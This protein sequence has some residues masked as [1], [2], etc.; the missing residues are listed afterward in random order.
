MNYIKI[1]SK[2][3]KIKINDIIKNKVQNTLKEK[4]NNYKS[5]IIKSKNND[6]SSK[7]NLF[8]YLFDKNNNKTMTLFPVGI[9]TKRTKLIHKIE[10]VHT[11][12]IK[13]NLI[14]FGKFNEK[15][16]NKTL[17][18]EKK[19]TNVPQL[20]NFNRYF[21]IK[22][23]RIM[24]TNKPYNNVTFYNDNKINKIKA[25]IK[26]SEI[27]KSIKI[28]ILVNKNNNFIKKRNTNNKQKDK[29]SKMKNISIIN[30]Y[31]TIEKYPIL[32]KNNTINNLIYNQKK[33]IKVN[34]SKNRNINKYHS[35]KIKLINIFNLDKSINKNISKLNNNKSNKTSI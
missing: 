11:N 3:K 21:K 31:H 25:T 14:N 33:D 2:I 1:N 35:R 15:N 20:I 8:E 22:N 19:P 12:P 18:Q 4:N 23:G 28:C 29:K 16:N 32:T 17:S 34:K 13:R 9:Q 27:I 10:S 30:N 5:K 7:N 26:K 6:K 24:K